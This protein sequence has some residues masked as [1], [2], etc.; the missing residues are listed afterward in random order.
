MLVYQK[1]NTYI[2]R[3]RG[4][5][6]KFLKAEERIHIAILLYTQTKLDALILQNGKS[7]HFQTIELSRGLSFSLLDCQLFTISLSCDTSGNL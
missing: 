6:R 7:V 2:I 3:S 5:S 1:G 4:G